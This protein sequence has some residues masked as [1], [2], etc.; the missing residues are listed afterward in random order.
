MPTDDNDDFQDDDNTGE[1]PAQLREAANRAKQ[2]KAEAEAAKRELAFVKAG[3]DTDSKLGKLLLA[4]YDGELTVDAIKEYTSDLP[5]F[6]GTTTDGDGDGETLE[7]GETN[8]TGE[9][10]SL[11]GDA[12]GDI[13]Q[14]PDPREEARKT[15]NQLIQDGGSV[16][17]ARATQFAMIVDAAIKGDERVRATS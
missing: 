15:A 8:S 12:Q 10:N 11:A 16:E 13:Q 17:D 5:G 9:R 14:N 7:D 3:I 1:T 2:H 4:S 6:T